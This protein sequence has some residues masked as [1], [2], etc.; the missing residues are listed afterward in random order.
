MGK[1]NY[2]EIEN[3]IGYHFKDKS[4]LLE[5]FTHSSYSS[6]HGG[7][8]NEK[9]EFLGDSVIGLIIADELFSKYR[10]SN[11]NEGTLTKIKARNVCNKD[12]SNTIDKLGLLNYLRLGNSMATKDISLKV[13]GDLCESIIGAIYFDSKDLKTTA[14]FINKYINFELEEIVD[15]KTKLQELLQEKHDKLPIYKTTKIN[16]SDDKP[17]FECQLFIDDKLVAS[18]NGSSKKQAEQNTAKIVLE[19]LI[20][21]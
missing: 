7:N 11:F 14:D 2:D 5:A 4:I 17:I 6:E 18:S 13:K 3:I 12:L 15:S 19:N 16:D 9:I 20:K 1:F 21:E 10:D 8:N